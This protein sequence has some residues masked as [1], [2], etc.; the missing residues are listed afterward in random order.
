[1]K[2]NPDWWKTLFDETYLITDARSVC[3][4]E[5]TCREV[6]ML[7]QVMEPHK[8][9][10]IVDLCGGHGRHALELCRRGYEDVT[11]V[12]CS[13][14]LIEL[15]A[16]TA[17]E[18]ELPVAFRERDARET[19]LPSGRFQYI[20]VMANSFGYFADPDDD[21]RFLREVYRLLA[22]GGSLLLDLANRDFITNGF[23]PLSWHEAD[24]DVVICRQRVLDHDIIY[25][26]ELV[27]SKKQ[28]LIR[29]ET[30]CVRLYTPER[31]TDLLLSER[32]DP[33][34]VKGDYVSHDK[35]G[36]CGFLTNRTIVLAKKPV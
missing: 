35:I 20:M 24:E 8:K 2:V 31:I 14:F 23:K 6:D 17:R 19:G 27:L 34:S 36:D 33:V 9:A 21:R 3:D 32:F 29:D 4:D 1:M 10:S 13:Q 30:Y 18:E 12:D 7:E 15:G 25:S 16:K 5:L 11:V 22:P 26:R 28:G